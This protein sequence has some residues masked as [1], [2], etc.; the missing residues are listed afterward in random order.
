MA[1]AAEFAD[2]LRRSQGTSSPRGSFLLDIF[3]CSNRAGI[4]A[5]DVAKFVL[6]VVTCASLTLLP[7]TADAGRRTGTWRYANPGWG[8]YGYGGYYPA[9]AGWGY[10]SHGYSGYGGGY[11]P[12]YY[13]GGGYYPAYGGTYPSYGHGYGYSGYGGPVYYGYQRRHSNTGGAM[14]AGLIGGMALGA[15]LARSSARAYRQCYVAPRRIAAAS[16]A[17]YIRRVRM[18][19]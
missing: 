8:G 6:T 18:C 2:D 19:R 15:I 7:T 5:S 3:P 10:R 9:H 17:T 12:G 14:A 13:G 16:G 11:Y 1:L 4:M